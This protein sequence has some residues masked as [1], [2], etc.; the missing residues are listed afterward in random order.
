[1]NL[2][3]FPSPGGKGGTIDQPLGGKRLADADVLALVTAKRTAKNAEKTA[4]LA[5]LQT[6]CTAAEREEAMLGSGSQQTGTIQR[7]V[8]TITRLE[9]EL[10]HLDQAYTGLGG[11]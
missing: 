4:A 5:A 9:G 7:L 2:V 3:F 11:S 6:A 8:Q 1:M 10:A